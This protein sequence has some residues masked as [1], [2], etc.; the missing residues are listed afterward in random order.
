MPAPKLQTPKV[1]SI[2][3]E[4]FRDTYQNG[5][6]PQAKPIEKAVHPLEGLNPNA[7]VLVAV[8][9]L[10]NAAK[11]FDRTAKVY[12]TRPKFPNTIDLKQVEYL[13]PYI[14][15]KGIRDIYKVTKIHAGTKQDIDPTCEDDR[16]RL[17]FEMKFEKQLFDDYK[18]HDLKIWHCF[19]DITV[20][21]LLVPKADAIYHRLVDDRWSFRT[22]NTKEY[23][24]CYHAYPAMM[25]PQV[26]RT[27][28]EEYKPSG[29]LECIFDPYAG[30]GTTLVEANLIGVNAIGTDLNPLARMMSRVKT[31]HYDQPQIVEWFENIC[32]H[33]KNYDPNIVRKKDF[34]NISNYTFWYTEDALLRLSYIQQLIDDH[35]NGCEFFLLC[36]A[37]TVREVSFT[38]N[39]EFKRFKMSEKSLEKFKPDVFDLFKRKVTRNI[40]GLHQFNTTAPMQANSKVCDFNSTFGIPDTIL[41]EGS[42]DMV[43]TSPPYGDSHTTV[44][45][46]QFS[47]WANEWFCYKEAASLDSML[48][49]GKKTRQELFTTITIRQE[50]DAIRA[51]DEKRYWEVVSF[52]ND[53]TLS[54]QNVAKVVRKGGV[55]CYVVGDRRVKGIQIPLDLF[56]AETFSHLGFKHKITLVR[57][58]PNKRMPAQTSPT[59]QAGL[60]VATMSQEFLVILEKQE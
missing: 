49:G 27:L 40:N 9:P 46:G 50:L 10:K 48:M 24:H 12:W 14:S 55:V 18:P 3:F 25:I 33:F 42:V 41:P 5:L 7:R 32:S 1:L 23:T 8:V 19:T 54:I 16:M 20:E 6:V 15:G 56:T 30:S 60:K 39:G 45:Y 34:S 51:L 29:R 36:L 43:V 35:A 17:V 21:E 44:A 53:Y 11:I 58:I 28:I 4:E 37:E 38:R 57:E 31:T 26:A 59:N 52:L 13:V 2:D 47:R 22:A